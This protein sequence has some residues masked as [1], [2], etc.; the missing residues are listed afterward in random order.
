MKKINGL[1]LKRVVLALLLVCTIG[2][3]SEYDNFFQQEDKQAHI[4][5]SIFNGAIGNLVAVKLGASKQEAF[6]I[7]LGTALVI[8]L[9]KELYDEHSYGG[10]ST[11]DMVANGIGGVIGTGSITLL[12]FNSGTW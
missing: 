7:G 1:Q 5:V 4:V 2:N 11:A 6:W 3:T 10:F 8:G 9:G 12:T